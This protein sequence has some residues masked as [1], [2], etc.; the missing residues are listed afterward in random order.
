MTSTTTTTTARRP[1]RT[2]ALA[3]VALAAAALLGLANADAAFAHDELI[4][5]S[6]EPGQVLETAPAEVKLTFSDDIIPVGTA[7]E[8]VDHHGE[9]IDSGE[10]VVA[11]PDVTATLPGGLEGEYQVRWRA[12]SSDGHVI[13]G[14]IDFGVGAG[15]TGVWTEEAPHGD[16]GTDSGSSGEQADGHDDS[17]EAS[18]GPGGWA[19]AGI[20]LGVVGVAALGAAVAVFATAARKRTPKA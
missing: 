8:V 12:V 3:A 9:T 13:D 7:V 15:A 6:P 14:T 11:G 5:S 19:I 17:A 20:V 1:A 18:D 4:S 2:I 10:A 16:S